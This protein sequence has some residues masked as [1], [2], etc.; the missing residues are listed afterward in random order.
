VQEA[1]IKKGIA[2]GFII[3]QILTQVARH[4]SHPFAMVGIINPHQIQQVG[5]CVDN[6]LKID[7]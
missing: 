5:K 3:A 4:P 2:F 1:G 6:T 7:F